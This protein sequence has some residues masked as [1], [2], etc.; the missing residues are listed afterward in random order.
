MQRL[1]GVGQVAVDITER[2]QSASGCENHSPMSCRA[3]KMLAHCVFVRL[4]TQHDW[5][6]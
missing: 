2:H 1:L 6:S 3:V 5:G 4:L